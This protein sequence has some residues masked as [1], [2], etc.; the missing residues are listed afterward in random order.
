MGSTQ[1]SEGVTS[2]ALAHLCVSTFQGMP[3]VSGM[4]PAEKCN[5]QPHSGK[6]GATQV[7]RRIKNKSYLF[8]P[9]SPMMRVVY[10]SDLD[11]MHE[12]VWP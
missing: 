9:P 1:A 4:T 8:S 3:D 10:D 12:L 7:Q 11:V 5:K 6:L 2:P